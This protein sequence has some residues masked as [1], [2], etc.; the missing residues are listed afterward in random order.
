MKSNSFLIGCF[1]IS[2][3]GLLPA[4]GQ[5]KIG[6]LGHI[7]PAGN[8]L[9][10]SGPSEAVATIHVKEDE[11]VEADAPL[12]TFA[13]RPQAEREVALA[14]LELR[15]AEGPERLA[16]EASTAR[17]E[18]ARLEAD[19][20]R[21]RRDRF[22]KM[23]GQN[24]A[25]PEM[26]RRILEAK[27][28]ELA[29]AA[30]AKEAESARIADEIKVLRAK[31]QLESARA[32]LDACTLRAP[33]RLTVVKISAQ[34]GVVPTGPVVSLADLSEIDVVVEV[35]AAD[36]LKVKPGQTATVTSTALAGSLTGRVVS[37]GRV[38]T[39][40][41]RVAEVLIRLDDPK[42]AAP[43]LQLEVNVTIDT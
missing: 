3:V 34:T 32:R 6:A 23:G 43:F 39:G 17:A 41:S 18:L 42:S 9:A 36:L 28:A 1:W 12:V 22:E 26:E 27:T 31:Q 14:E 24:V 35:F 4:F 37:V 13:G 10:L 5:S 2:L 16:A 25:A 21:I 30:A 11:L 8:I 40:R 29:A 20:A 19:A 7:I 33:R 15:D 38:I